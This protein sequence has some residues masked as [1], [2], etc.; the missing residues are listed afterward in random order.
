VRPAGSR[1][2]LLFV[3]AWILFAMMFATNVVR[4][5]Y[6]AVSLVEDGDYRLDEYKKPRLPGESDDQA[7]LHSDIFWHEGHAYINN[8][9][10]AS[11]VAAVV[12]LPFKPV[13]G[14]LE[15]RSKAALAKGGGAVDTRFATPHP[16]RE[17]FY[18]LAR[19]NGWELKLGAVAAITAVLLMAPLSALVVLL[20]FDFLAARGVARSRAALLAMLLGFGTPILF[21]TAHLN[22]NMM[23][24]YAAFGA[25][26]ALAPRGPSD[27]LVP[28]AG[29]ARH[30]AAGLLAGVAPMS[31]YSG[32]VPL[33]CLGVWVLAG[34]IR[35]RRIADVVLFGAGAALTLLVQLHSQRV[36][37]GDWWKP[38]A[39]WMTASNFSDRGYQGLAWPAPDLFL[40]N[41]VE[42]R[43]GLF[44][45]GPLLLFALVP[46]RRSDSSAPLPF[47]PW[48][49]VMASAFA[50]ML[51]AAA[52]QFGRMQWN[53]G[54]R[55]L[56]P[57][58]P[59]FFLAASNHLARMRA[60]ALAAV[61]VIAVLHS[62]VVSMRRESVLGVFGDWRRFLTE[63]PRLPWL[64]V[65]SRTATGRGRIPQ[66]S[67]V[68]VAVTAG[69]LLLVLA[70]WMM[71]R[72]STRPAAGSTTTTP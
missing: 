11:V 27:R 70:L 53:T 3:T 47:R 33:L 50:F 57:L 14:S 66:G 52:N 22:H 9:V 32:V 59:F 44:A 65:L 13:L 62:W 41:L 67:G 7:G 30:F 5:H 10:G 29:A 18:R 8:N 39:H 28:R 42:P 71:A 45:Y 46:P 63:G 38:P 1:R 68:H 19:E 26:L 34:A 16:N 20:A 12:L 25:F 54:V 6:P 21:R 60:P 37:F 69:V 64:D 51:F 49:W 31:D 55:Y 40:Q 48:A 56:M 58:V 23:V 43:W 61:G 15:A 24:M 4:E 72:R 2:F 36:C 35:S 17:R